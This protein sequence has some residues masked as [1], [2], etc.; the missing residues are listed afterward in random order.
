[1]RCHEAAGYPACGEPGPSEPAGRGTT[2]ELLED[3]VNTTGELVTT[4]GLLQVKQHRNFSQWRNFF[5]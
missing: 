3:F 1:M 2:E 4:E 5:E